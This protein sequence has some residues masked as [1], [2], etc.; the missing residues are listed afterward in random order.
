MSYSVYLYYIRDGEKSPDLSIANPSGELAF[1]TNG[2]TV[3]SSP[4]LCSVS[5]ARDDV[6]GI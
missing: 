4:L 6:E 2:D 3:R 5:L 1:V